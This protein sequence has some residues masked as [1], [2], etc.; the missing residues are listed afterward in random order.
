[1]QNLST[2]KSNAVLSDQ[3]EISSDEI[4]SHANTNHMTKTAILENTRLQMAIAIN[5]HKKVN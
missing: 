4:K 5:V 1:M 3:C 2:T